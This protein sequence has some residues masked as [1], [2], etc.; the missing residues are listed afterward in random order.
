MAESGDEEWLLYYISAT[1]DP[2]G[3]LQFLQVI[4]PRGLWT[5]FLDALHA[6]PMNGHFGIEK[7]QKAWNGDDDDDV[8]KLPTP[9][10][11]HTTASTTSVWRLHDSG[12]GYRLTFLLARPIAPCQRSSLTSSWGCTATWWPES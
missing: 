11:R 6:G 9:I 8:G 4:V 1:Y 2:N 7:T 12:G 5:Q 3:S 10:I